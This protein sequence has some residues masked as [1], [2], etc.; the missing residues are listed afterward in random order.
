MKL[1]DE[2]ATSNDGEEIVPLGNGGLIATEV[3]ARTGRFT[4]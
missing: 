1:D 4:E 2:C 3:G